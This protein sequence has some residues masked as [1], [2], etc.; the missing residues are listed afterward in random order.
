MVCSHP[1]AKLRELERKYE[2]QAV[3]HEEL[4]LEMNQLRKV[5][6]TS[7]RTLP[8]VQSGIEPASASLS[9]NANANH[10]AAGLL[11]LPLHSILRCFLFH[12]I[13]FSCP[14]MCA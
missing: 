2:M 8:M 3:K 12:F 6:D 14:S 13:G 1:Q 5:A 10:L 4:T 7:S 11:L 9:E